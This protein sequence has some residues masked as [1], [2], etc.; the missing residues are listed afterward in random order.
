MKFHSDDIRKYQSKLENFLTEGD[1]DHADALRDIDKLLKNLQTFNIGGQ[2][3]GIK[4]NVDRATMTNTLKT[5][6][7]SSGGG[8][9]EQ[10]LANFFNKL[11][12]F[13]VQSEELTIGMSISQMVSRIIFLQYIIKII[14]T[15]ESKVTGT[16]MEDLLAN[17]LQG[18]AVGRDGGITDIKTK[19]ELIS[20]KFRQRG[21]NLSVSPVD[22]SLKNLLIDILVDNRTIKFISIIN[23][24][25]REDDNM[26]VANKIDL[27]SFSINKTNL[28][29]FLK[30]L[31]NPNIIN[32]KDMKKIINNKLSK[33]D[34]NAMKFSET[35]FKIAAKGLAK[36]NPQLVG[37]DSDK[38]L[39]E[40]A[41]EFG[42][43]IGNTY[44]FNAVKFHNSLKLFFNS[45]GVG[46]KDTYDKLGTFT[47]TFT[48]YITD[49]EDIKPSN[50]T[51]AAKNLQGSA[52]N[53]IKSNITSSKKE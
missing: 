42:I 34:I 19:T 10:K 43:Q 20:L 11:Q 37:E 32:P 15:L 22:G 12:E 4:T 44:E 6:V 33:E 41:G 1:H 40:V 50:L 8:T 23:S 30:N 26:P 45:L 31:S 28:V 13:F 53:L 17:I 25:I 16:I 18:T 52:L 24:G 51:D 5:I 46:I 2:Y 49:A 21:S 29:S 48:E 3:G 14:S 39:N 7:G 9:A 47:T 27:Y 38:R 35:K 36:V